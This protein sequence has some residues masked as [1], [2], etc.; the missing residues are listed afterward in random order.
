[1]AYSLGLRTRNDTLAQDL[2]RHFDQAF[3]SLFQAPTAGERTGWSLP[4]E[5]QETSEAYTITAEVP[6]VAPADVKVTLENDTLK[7]EGEKKAPAAPAEGQ[8]AP[9]THVAERVYGAFS[10]LL[11]F[12][13]R[14]DGEAITAEVKDG[15]LTVRLPKAR[16]AQP[17]TIQVQA[18]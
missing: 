12:P 1:M 14:L 6:G 10:R 17:R 9:A 4:V 13:I 3:R 8:Q 18:R 15:L 5:V 7:L 2:D 16:E 11:R